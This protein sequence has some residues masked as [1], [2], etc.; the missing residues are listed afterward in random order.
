MTNTTNT[1]EGKYNIYLGEDGQSFGLLSYNWVSNTTNFSTTS[2]TST[3]I[4][5]SSYLLTLWSVLICI[6]I[7]F[8]CFMALYGR[9]IAR[10]FKTKRYRLYGYHEI[11]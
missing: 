3:T 2:T 1:E 9:G 10:C 8:S 5:E 11:L 6:F 4:T 7:L